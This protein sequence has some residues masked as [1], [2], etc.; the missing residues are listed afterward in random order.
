VSGRRAGT[1]VVGLGNTYRRDD[2]VGPA[3][4]AALE[5]L[6]LPNVVVASGIADP[7]DLVEAWSGAGL[8]I[9]IDAMVGDAATPSQPGGIRRCTLDD[10][11]AGSDGLSSHAVDVGHSHELAAALGRAPDELVV[12]AIEVADTGHG[13]GLTPQVSRAVPEAARLVVREIGRQV[14][15]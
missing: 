6:G 12:F 1:V 9:V 7:M 13:T 8:A 3:V 15:D 4:A 14:T 10:L 11:R 5:G 2:G